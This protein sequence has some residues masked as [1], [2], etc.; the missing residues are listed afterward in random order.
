MTRTLCCPWRERTLRNSMSVVAT[1]EPRLVH[2]LPGRARIHLPGWSGQ[3]QRALE[4]RLREL[5][6]VRSVQAN[7]LT[8]NVLV[9]F[10]PAAAERTIVAAVRQIA[11]EVMAATEPASAP[12]LPFG[13]VADEPSRVSVPRERRDKM[14][15][16][17]IRVP[18]L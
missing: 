8:G 13:R 14:I 6:L 5:P 11:T 9:L 10:D 1:Q 16:A 7:G 17:R 15:R 2:A 18:G 3:G 4:K 12:P